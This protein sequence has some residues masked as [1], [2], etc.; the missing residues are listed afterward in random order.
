LVRMCDRCGRPLPD[1]NIR[2]V[3]A[4]YLVMLSSIWEDRYEEKLIGM[5]R[6]NKSL[7]SFLVKLD[8]CQ[9]CRSALMFLLEEGRLTIKALEDRLKKFTE[10]RNSLELTGRGP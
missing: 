8:L 6:D 1:S 7:A 10:F 2:D 3:V 9:D 4:A 5:I